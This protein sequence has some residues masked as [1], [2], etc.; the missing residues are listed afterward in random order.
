[1]E[2]FEPIRTIDEKDNDESMYWCSPEK[3]KKQRYENL[4]NST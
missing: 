3:L 4:E 2:R 1:M